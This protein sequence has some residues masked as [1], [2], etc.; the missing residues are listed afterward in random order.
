MFPSIKIECCVGGIENVEI[1]RCLFGIKAFNFVNIGTAFGGLV[2]FLLLYQ[3]IGNKILL[4]LLFF[5]VG[6]S[7]SLFIIGILIEF[8]LSE[9]VNCSIIQAL[10]VLYEDEKKNVSYPDECWYC[11]W[12]F[13]DI[14]AIST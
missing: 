10:S 11:I 4:F 13:I 1:V 9:D 8:G 6:V 5:L 7:F 14:I 3:F 2:I 12:W